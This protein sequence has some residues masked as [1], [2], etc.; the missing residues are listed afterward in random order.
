MHKVLAFVLALLWTVSAQAQSGLPQFSVPSSKGT[1]VTGWANSSG[2]LSGQVLT[3]QTGAKPAFLSAASALDSICAT[4]NA[5]LYRASGGWSCFGPGTSGGVLGFGPGGNPQSSAALLNNALVVGQTNA[6]PTT[7]GTVGTAT[8]VLH[9]GSPNTY[10]QIVS[11][12]VSPNNITDALLRQSAGLSVIGRASNTTGNVADITAGSDFQV[13]SRTG[14]SIAFSR[15]NLA[16]SNAVINN[17]PVTNLN[18][19]TSA[20][21]T[22]FWR[23]DGTWATPASSAFLTPKVTT[24]TSGSGN[25][26]VTG[27][28]LY[29]E[30]QMA[31]GGG[32]GAGS[33]T[34]PGGGGNGGNTTF[35]TATAAGGTGGSATGG[36]TAA[37]GAGTSCTWAL[38]GNTGGAGTNGAT[39]LLGGF[40]GSTAF[41]GGGAPNPAGIAGVNAVT[42]SGGGGSGAG[43]TSTNVNGGG[44]GG[45]ASC[46]LRINS[47]TGSYA[48]AVGA[49]GTAGTAGGSG[50]A[51]GSGAAGL[52]I[53]QEFYQ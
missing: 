18:N 11:A 5:L 13:L 17:L 28:P 31:G 30:V 37:G 9:G 41:F 53:V 33:G 43:Q 7:L 32:G 46:F 39:W 29:L 34:A 48:Y 23:G 21:A 35:S 20:S 47:P 4:L 51:G 8:T 3:W 52:I 38:T 45:G 22:T 6:P 19:G 26:S 42:N 25:H 40:G 1:N 27:T 15:V 12:D 50:N 14:T 36:T 24:Y 2:T 44:G 16:S 10:Q 49:A